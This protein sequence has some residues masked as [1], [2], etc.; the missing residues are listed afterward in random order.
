[1]GCGTSMQA[2]AP[3]PPPRRRPRCSHVAVAAD[4]SSVVAAASPNGGADSLAL[5]AWHVDVPRDC[6]PHL[7]ATAWR[8]P[9]A[10]PLFDLHVS[11]SGHVVAAESFVPTWSRPTP[12]PW[13]EPDPQPC[14]AHTGVRKEPDDIDFFVDV[15]LGDRAPF[16]VRATALRVVVRSLA[17]GAVLHSERLHGR[18]V[19]RWIGVWSAYEAPVVIVAALLRKRGSDAQTR[20]RDTM[21]S[22][23]LPTESTHDETSPTTPAG[24][25]RADAAE[26]NAFS[27]EPANEPSWLQLQ[28]RTRCLSR[29]GR[30]M[31]W[32][33]GR[34]LLWPTGW[35]GSVE[36][37]S[38]RCGTLVC[39]V[40]LHASVV[41]GFMLCGPGRRRAD[42]TI[43]LCEAVS[44]GTQITVHT[45]DGDAEAEAAGVF[46]PPG[47]G[48]RVGLNAA[49]T[50]VPRTTFMSH[51]SFVTTA[52]GYTASSKHLVPMFGAVAPDGATVTLCGERQPF[53]GDYAYARWRVTRGEQE[54]EPS[55]WDPVAAGRW[56]ASTSPTLGSVLPPPFFDSSGSVALLVGCTGPRGA[57]R[58]RVATVGGPEVPTAASG[59]ATPRCTRLAVSSD[60]GT[61][62]V[63]D[64]A[65]HAAAPDDGLVRLH[66]VATAR[67]V[68]EAAGVACLP[69]DIAAAVVG[70]GHT[71]PV[72]CALGIH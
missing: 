26:S 10:G 67:T 33:S 18:F 12:M 72:P 57:Q 4:G 65:A 7:G 43:V 6:D 68:A 11:R 46:K 3:L 13:L 9:L 8:V 39:S 2:G 56:Q 54:D 23:R 5:V 71:T 59:V 14:C 20:S 36:V 32:P 52:A 53:S 64:S 29:D 16:A 47:S 70:F 21:L 24:T 44:D 25:R 1:M 38:A 34:F 61:V 49:S 45:V 66:T 40:R 22:L 27:F 48:R 15:P 62:A 19:E 42:L 37:Y 60:A 69:A 41:D 35:D 50:V 63:A 58:Y 28:Q 31:L 55:R 30:F 51:V 17:T